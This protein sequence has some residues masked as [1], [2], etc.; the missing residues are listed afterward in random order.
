MEC[1]RW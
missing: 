1:L